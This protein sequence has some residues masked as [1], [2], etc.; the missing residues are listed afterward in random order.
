MRRLML[1]SNVIY[2]KSDYELSQRK[3]EMF[4]KYLKMIQWGRREPVKFLEEVFG[5][6][7]TDHQRYVLLSTWNTLRAVWLMSRNSG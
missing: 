1:M 6:Q 5:L 2:N 4:E 3:I 7:F